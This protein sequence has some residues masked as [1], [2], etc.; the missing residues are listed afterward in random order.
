MFW[1]FGDDYKYET[2]WD[3]EVDL[4]Q[5]V[6]PANPGHQRAGARITDLSVVLSRKPVPDVVWAFYCVIQDHVLQLFRE[7]GLSGFDVRP[8]K[9]RFKNSSEKPPR[10]WEL[11]VT[12]W[13]GIAA[14]ESG[15][16]LDEE[17]SCQVCGSLVYSGTNR[18]ETIIDEHQWDGSDLFF[19]WPMPK[20]IF[21]TQRVVD[22]LRGR[23]LTGVAVKPLASLK[24]LDEFGPG[25]LHY[26][27]PDD[28]AHEL[29]DPLGIY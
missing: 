19:I 14:P 20:F 10:L 2:D 23:R 22:L 29:G 3:D 26:Y 4:E 15:I 8:V 17:K 28:R 12:G 5:I 9:A 21:V 16:R 27:L 25:R 18:P 7:T 6:C 11:C 13:G 24:D 1:H